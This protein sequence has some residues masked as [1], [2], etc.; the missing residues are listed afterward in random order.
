MTI[1]ADNETRRAQLRRT[2]YSHYLRTGR[3]PVEIKSALGEDIAAGGYWVKFN[4][5]H[6]PE[7]GRFTFA[8]GHPNAV[9]SPVISE[10]RNAT[11]PKIPGI[12]QSRT[13]G[14]PR[15]TSAETDVGAL[16][17]RQEGS[18]PENPGLIST[19]KGDRGGIS[20]GS[21]QLSSKTGTANEFIL[22]PEARKW[23]KEFKDLKVGTAAFNA[24]WKEIANHDPKGFHAAQKAFIN[25][26][27]YDAAARKVMKQTG[28]DLNAQ[29][30]ALKQVTFST[31]VQH[32]P[33]GGP[34]VIDEA[35]RRTDKKLKRTDPQYKAALIN[36]I[37]DRRT[38]IF[39]SS[40]IK[41][42]KLA[43]QYMRLGDRQKATE[44]T[45]RARNAKNVVNNRYPKERKQ[46]LL[47][48]EQER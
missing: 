19:G 30:N 26:T 18:K 14:Q 7:N 38:E 48:L 3:V 22:S 16:A 5:Y 15:Q 40:S 41:N 12:R 37:Y 34:L 24:K 23:A 46:A 13:G 43:E 44:Y 28:F 42:R 29:G 20:Y 25:R 1:A 11:K 45:K 32:G 33:S 8:P 10:R 36:N 47:L 17:A 4:P 27:I 39:E 21:Y 35:I 2:G 6:D 31:A 9:S